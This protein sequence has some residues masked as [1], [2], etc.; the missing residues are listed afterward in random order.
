MKELALIGANDFILEE[1]SFDKRDMQQFLFYA[2]RCYS[3]IY[4]VYISI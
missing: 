4:V 1:V 2:V 3:W